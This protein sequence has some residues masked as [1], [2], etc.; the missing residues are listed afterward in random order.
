MWSIFR[1][2]FLWYQHSDNI[3]W[4]YSQFFLQVLLSIISILCCWNYTVQMFFFDKLT[5]RH[6][7]HLHR[8]IFVT[9]LF[10]LFSFKKRRLKSSLER[11]TIY[12]LNTTMNWERRRYRCKLD[13]GE[14][15]LTGFRDWWI[16]SELSITH[17][18][19]EHIKLSTVTLFIFLRVWSLY[20]EKFLWNK[21]N[22][23][24][25]EGSKVLLVFSFSGTLYSISYSKFLV[26]SMYPLPLTS[27]SHPEWF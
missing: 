15:F 18:L 16:G 22:F 9:F 5:P 13:M 2:L 11:K 4:C 21:L 24:E 6:V 27:R 7:K 20:G 8:P 19:F 17:N 23:I 26:C 12:K 25:R 10:P 14:Q 1:G 3:L